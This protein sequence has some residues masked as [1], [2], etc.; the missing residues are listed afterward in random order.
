M[1]STRDQPLPIDPA[2]QVKL[3]LLA[4]FGTAGNILTV[5]E[6]SWG[7]DLPLTFTAAEV[8]GYLVVRLGRGSWCLGLR[9]PTEGCDKQCRVL[10]QVHI[11]AQSDLEDKAYLFHDTYEC[12]RCGAFLR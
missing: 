11:T 3:E 8:N 1:S 5:T 10:R 12:S 7:G 9:C 2:P 4:M 6:L